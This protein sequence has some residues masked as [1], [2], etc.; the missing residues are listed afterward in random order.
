VCWIL[1][2]TLHNT[3]LKAS[4]QM[5]F[6]GLF[7]VRSEVHSG[8]HSIAH[9]Q[10]AWL[11]G[12]KCSRWHTPSLLDLRSQVSSQDAS[13][14][15]PKYASEYVL[16]YTTGH[17]LKDT[18]NCTR[19][20]TPS[21][22]DCTLPIALDGTLLAC[23]TVRSLLLSIGH[24][25]PAWRTLPSKLSRRSQVH[26]EYTP[27]YTSEYVLKYTPRHAL[28]ETPNCTRWYTS[29]LLDCTLP[30]TLDGTLP[31]C[32]TVRSQ[33]S[34]Q[35]TPKYTTST[36]QSIPP[37]TFSSTLPGILSRT[38]P[39]ALEGTLPACLTVRSQVSSQDAL[40]HTPEHTLKYTPNCIRWHTPSLLDHTLPNTLS[41]RSQVH[42]RV[43][44]KYAPNCS[45][46]YTPSLLGSTLP[47]TLSRGKT[48]SISLDYVLP[49]MLLH[50]RSRDLLSCRHREAWCM[51]V[52]VW[53]AAGGGW[54]VACGM[55]CVAGSICWL[56]SWRRS[57]WYCTGHCGSDTVSC[58]QVIWT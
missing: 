14:Y 9:S 40:K 11:Y 44:L 46:W 5:H 43:T 35:D 57:I 38:L 20:H 32:W 2:I 12:P 16:E 54:R 34:S 45:R 7:Q 21:L 8:L 48:L 3:N 37:S 55:W 36:L 10:P 1:Y 27:K 49:C 56:K 26:S 18:P 19:W 29:S 4:C 23:L 47:S 39:I 50:A 13:M 52:S 24:S 33:V 28:K 42:L 6:I 30:I 51:A 58:W 25:Q 41:G 31:A 22:L 15:T 17:A 53:R